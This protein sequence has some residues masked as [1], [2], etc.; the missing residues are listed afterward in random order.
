MKTKRKRAQALLPAILGGFKRQAQSQP[1]GVGLRRARV[2]DRLDGDGNPL[3]DI[4][5]MVG[6]R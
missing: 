1:E 3:D 2:D 5:R 4:M 6:R